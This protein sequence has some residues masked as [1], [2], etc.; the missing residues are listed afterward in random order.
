[1]FCIKISMFLLVDGCLFV[2]V[3]PCLRQSV[4]VVDPAVDADNI[5]AD[6]TSLTEISLYLC[7]ACKTPVDDYHE[8]VLCENCDT[9]F[10]ICCQGIPSR[11]YSRLNNSSVIWTCLSCHS[12]NYS[13][14]RSDT[15]YH[16]NNTYLPN[17]ETAE[18]EDDLSIESL[19][20]GALP[21][22][23]S[24]LKIK[25]RTRNKVRPLKILNVNCQSIPSKIGARRLLLNKHKPDV[26][27]A[28]ETWL[29]PNIYD[30]ELEADDFVIYRQD[31]QQFTRA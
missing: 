3:E 23:E 9:W 27:V 30:A 11:E 28:T 7:G 26:V 5:T 12:Q 16:N 6:E 24:S 14:T 25:K 10:H 19:E 17:D 8:A 2:G 20:D 18:N 1:M 31:R 21:K 4:W 15:T 29:N 13:H 22:H